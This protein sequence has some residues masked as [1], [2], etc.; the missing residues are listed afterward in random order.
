MLP[1]IVIDIRG[2]ALDVQPVFMWH[3][4]ERLCRSVLSRIKAEETELAAVC[5]D[6]LSPVYLRVTRA[7]WTSALWAN[8]ERVAY[9]TGLPFA[10]AEREPAAH[11]IHPPPLGLE[12]LRKE[13]RC[14]RGARRAVK[15][16]E[17][18]NED[19]ERTVNIAGFC[20]LQLLRDEPRGN[21]FSGSSRTGTDIASY[22]KRAARRGCVTKTLRF[23]EGKIDQVFM[24]EEMWLGSSPA[25]QSG[26]S[27]L[28]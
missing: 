4:R 28:L 20:P 11:A 17:L 15:P 16:F 1:A 26:C 12:R 13:G 18:S 7:G 14:N 9:Y 22:R 25:L 2:T 24:F 5:T 10:I 3:K 21:L 27:V 19:L 23:R 6:A 8:H